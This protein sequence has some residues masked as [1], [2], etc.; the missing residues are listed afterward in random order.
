MQA[1]T[2]ILAYMHRGVSPRAWSDQ[3]HECCGHTDHGNN[4]NTDSVVFSPISERMIA[5]PQMHGEAAI[6]ELR[7]QD[8]NLYADSEER[9]AEGVVAKVFAALCDGEMLLRDE[10]AAGH[11]HEQ[12]T[13]SSSYYLVLAI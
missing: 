8:S 2:L 7:A 1:R 4:C 6:E 3:Q 12:I 5:N 13:D 10:D 11:T 9:P